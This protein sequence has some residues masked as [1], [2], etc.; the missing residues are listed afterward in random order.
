VSLT[1][2]SHHRLCF[3]RVL[4]GTTAAVTSLPFCKH[5]EGDGST[6]AFS[7][8][9]VYLWFMW[10]VSPPPSP[11]G[12]SSHS[13]FYKL[14]HSK[15]AWQVSPLLPSPAGLFIY[16][17]MRG[18]LSPPFGAQGTLPSLL[19]VFCCCC[20]LFSLVFFSFFPGWGSVCPGGYAD[21]P[22]GSLWEYHVPLSSPGDLCLS[23]Q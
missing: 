1:L 10:E 17:S 11:V 20:L 6:T 7:G 12:L 4:L 18:C 19:H 23:S 14:S 21:L 3:F 22:Q 9:R 13:H 2:T 16:I 15:V 8:R 5:T